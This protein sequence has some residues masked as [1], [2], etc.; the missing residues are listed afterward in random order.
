[1]PTAT[2]YAI[3]DKL[4]PICDIANVPVGSVLRRAG[5]PTDF[6]EQPDPTVDAAKFFEVFDAFGEV[7]GTPDIATTIGVAYARGPFSAPVYAFSCS[8]TVENGFTRL[9]QFKP[10]I[11]PV[12][13]NVDRSKGKLTVTFESRNSD[14][15][16][17]SMFAL[18]ELVYMTECARVSTGEHILPIAVS[19]DATATASAS[20]SEYMGLQLL[21]SSQT[22]IVFSDHDA[23]LPLLAQND[24][25]WSV[26]EAGLKQKLEAQESTSSTS[27]TSRR[28]KRVIVEMLAGGAVSSDY[29]AE[30]LYTS[31]RSLQRKLNEEGTTFQN[32]LSE[33][34]AEL[35]NHYL[36][37]PELSLAEIS[38]L[39]GFR[40]QTSY[41]RAHQVWS[42]ST[43]VETRKLLLK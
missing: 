4:K 10:L 33:T 8:D 5:L 21:E 9:A 35:S 29:V 6:C 28:V 26:L 25:L 15:L 22:Q 20:V 31:K 30:K 17:P 19:C 32:I 39:L 42:G 18:F 38:Y 13:L 11:A 27:S 36:A 12:N 43:P 14:Q 1:M 34:R 2:R 41:F 40:D 7:L 23:K 24:S 16:I 37:Q 3:V